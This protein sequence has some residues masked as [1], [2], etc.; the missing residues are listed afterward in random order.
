MTGKIR[1]I[2]ENKKRFTEIPDITIIKKNGT[3]IIIHDNGNF[4]KVIHKKRN[5]KNKK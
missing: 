1:S 3:K 2:E 5:H 4:V